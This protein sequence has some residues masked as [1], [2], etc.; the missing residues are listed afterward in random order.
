MSLQDIR[1]RFRSASGR[2]DL[3]NEQGQAINPLVDQFINDGQRFLDTQHFTAH[4]KARKVELVH[5]GDYI[6]AI[7]NIRAIQEVWISDD[8]SRTVLQKLELAQ[9]RDLFPNAVK[10]TVHEGEDVVSNGSF[11]DNSSWFYR[12][13]RDSGTAGWTFPGSV[14]THIPGEVSPLLQE[15]YNMVQN[16]VFGK[17]YRIWVTFVSFTAGSVTVRFGGVNNSGTFTF[18]TSS[19]PSSTFTAS[20][21][22]IASESKQLEFIPSSNFVGSIT[23]VQM[24]QYEPIL[25]GIERAR[26]QYFAINIPKLGPEQYNFWQLTDFL[27]GYTDYQE[28]QYG[29][30]DI[31]EREKYQSIILMPPADK[32]YTANVF[33]LFYSSVLVNDTDQNFWTVNY[34]NLLTNAALR[35]MEI[36]YRN[37]AGEMAWTQAMQRELLQIDKDN[38]E[39]DSYGINQLR[40]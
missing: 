24:K 8:D 1:L 38:A 5:Q 35:E 9:L 23:Q 26:P 28:I 7:K 18:G 29:G 37:T 36:H 34:P 19:V 12:S 22:L 21:D 3:V 14:A 13:N 39:Q 10:S 6:L 40:G 17:R 33:G 32:T 15:P 31:Q 25:E 27:S 11:T 4:G 30:T 20:L 16:P 2:F